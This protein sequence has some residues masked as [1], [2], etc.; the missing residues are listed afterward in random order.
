MLTRYAA[1]LT[2]HM[3]GSLVVAALSCDPALSLIVARLLHYY[4]SRSELAGLPFL[5]GF[6]ALLVRFLAHAT[7]D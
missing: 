1:S 6:S 4:L 2:S 5:K 7:V 3:L